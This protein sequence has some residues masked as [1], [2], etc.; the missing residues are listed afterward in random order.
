LSAGITGALVPHAPLLLPEVSGDEV[1]A[2]T[3]AI[4]RALG[5]IAFDDVELIVLLSPHSRETGVYSAVA[6]S[7]DDFSVPGVE[8]RRPTHAGAVDSLTAMWDK[9]A[10][11]APVDH[12]VVVPLMLL[13]SARTPV[14]AA[15]LAEVDEETGSFDRA[16]AHAVSF[17]RAIARLSNESR[18]LLVVSAQTACALTP[19]APL[20]ERAE[21]KQT[22]SEVIAALRGDP[23]SL[24]G[25]LED[26]W[27]RGGS[28]SPGALAV[29]AEV[30]SGR[31]SEVLAYEYPFGVGYVVARVT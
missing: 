24:R 6:G 5:T 17:A 15:G 26:L 31:A 27:K 11:P 16:R 25:S 9:P 22:E 10:L 2:Q 12:G 28:C 18:L 23:G 20:T 4:R 1:A 8:L 3:K 13:A 7:L 29:Y 21:A 19:R 30:F 14:V